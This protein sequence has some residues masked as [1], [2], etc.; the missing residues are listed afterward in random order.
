MLKIRNLLFAL[1]LGSALSLIWQLPNQAQSN[2]PSPGTAGTDSGAATGASQT[3]GF[4]TPT[5][6]TITIPIIS[7]ISATITAGVSTTGNLTAGGTIATS[8]A[9][10]E[11]TSN[12]I[13]VT[14]GVTGNTIV[15]TLSPQAQVAVNQ[16]ATAILQGLSNTSNDSVSDLLT[17]SAGS[18]QAIDS[19]L[20]RLTDA[21]VS[22]ELAQS[23]VTSITGLFASPNASL[24]LA[25]ATSGQL[26]ASTKAIKGVSVIAQAGASP[27][28]NI[29]KLNDAI[30]AYNAIILQSKPEVLRNLY[31]DSVFVGIGRIIKELRISIQ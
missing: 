7:G 26:V 22:P 4:S 21:G 25:Q 24:P 30:V 20:K 13:T 16:L 12:S 6:T 14:D 17:G 11:S 3:S 31:K 15:I 27:N 19:L 18:R 9:T 8:T 10:I 5:R 29:N 1:S 28:V 23:L 2:S